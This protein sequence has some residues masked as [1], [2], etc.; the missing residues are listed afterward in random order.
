MH[1]GTVDFIMNYRAQIY[2]LAAF[3]VTMGAAYASGDIF[4]TLTV[5]IG[6]R[7]VPN[8]PFEQQ[9]M[10]RRLARASSLVTGVIGLSVYSPQL[11]PF[12]SCSLSTKTTTMMASAIIGV[13]MTMIRA[14]AIRAT[15]AF[16]RAFKL[17][18]PAVAI[19]ITVKPEGCEEQAYASVK[20]LLMASSIK[21]YLLPMCAGAAV[22][23][24]AGTAYKYGKIF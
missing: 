18:N 15:I 6:H 22:A 4:D 5:N 20:S 8:V 16:V 2:L 17:R 7:Y 19:T 1:G 9:P 11:V 23:A 3:M 10:L 13:G 14:G 12:L 24:L 21:C